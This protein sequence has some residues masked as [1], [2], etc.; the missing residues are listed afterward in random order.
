MTVKNREE[1]QEKKQRG[2]T[3]KKEKERKV[4]SVHFSTVNPKSMNPKPNP[5]NPKHT[6]ETLNAQTSKHTPRT[7]NPKLLTISSSP[8]LLHSTPTSPYLLTL[9]NLLTK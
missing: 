4:H 5:L 6:P 7:L 1:K 3:R 2:K 9:P 8:L